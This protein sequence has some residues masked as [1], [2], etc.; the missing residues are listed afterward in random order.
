M[1]LA[2]RLNGVRGSRPTHKLELI[3][4]GG[5]STNVEFDCGGPFY[6]FIDGGS[7]LAKRGRELI[8]GQRHTRFHFL[9]THTHWD[10][11]LGF[12][13]FSPLYEPQNEFIFYA[14]DTSKATFNHLFTSQTRAENLPVPL[15]QIRAKLEFKTITPNESFEIEPG[16]TIKT[17]QLNHQG[18]TLGYRVECDGQSVCMITDNAPIEG[19]YMGEGMAECARL[20]PKEFEKNFNLG[21]VGFLKKADS[22]VFDTHFTESTLKSDWGH[23]TP[24]R[25]LEFCMQANVKRLIL[26]HHAPEDTDDDVVAKV[27][28]IQELAKQSG[29]EVVAAAEGQAWHHP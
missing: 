9:I 6:L 1:P 14:S 24:H 2:L 17:F 21:L 10:H 15:S 4:H 11:I 27:K 26:F 18:V 7:G 23:S 13:F 5:N 12:P 29:I 3:Y 22:V 19:N 16:V 8:H 25:A 28:S 20:N